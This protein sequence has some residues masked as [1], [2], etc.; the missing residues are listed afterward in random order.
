[1]TLNPV[2]FPMDGERE[3]ADNAPTKGRTGKLAFIVPSIFYSNRLFSN[4]KCA[5]IIQRDWILQ[6]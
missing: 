6:V 1:M 4:D 5:I 3:D 2:I